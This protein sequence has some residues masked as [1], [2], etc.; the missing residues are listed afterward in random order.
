MESLIPAAEKLW[1]EWDLRTFVMISLLLQAILIF[2]GSL[3]KHTSNLLISLII[4]SAYLLA[5]WVAVFALG[6]LSNG[7]GNSGDSKTKTASDPWN[8]NDELLA[9][10]P[11][12][13]LLH[14]GGPDTITA[15]A[16]EDNEL[17]LRHLLGLIFQ[18]SVAIYVFQRSIRTTRL[19]A[20]AILMFF[21]GIVKY[22]ERTYALMSA[23]ADNLRSSMVSPPDPGPNYAKFMEEY[24]SKTNA[25]LD[26]RIKTEEEPDTLKFNVEEGTVFNDSGDSWILLKAKHFYLIFRCLIV[27]LILSFHDRNDSRSFFANLKAEKAFRVVEIE[28]SFIYQVL[29]TKAPVI[30]YKTVGPWLRVFT[31]TLM[32]ISLIL[33]IFTGKS[34]YRGMDVTVTYI[35]FGG[36]LFLETWAFTLLVSS[37]QAFLWLKGQERHKA[38][39]FVLSCISFPLSYRQNKP[40]WSRKM[41]QCNLM[42]ICLADEKHGVIAWIMSF[43]LVK[44]WC[45]RKDTPVSSPLLE[46]LFE[47]LKS[48]SSTAEDSRG[49]KRLCNSRGEL[50]LKMMGYH[51]MFGWSVNVDFDESILLWHIA[52]ELC[53]QHDNKKEN[54]NNRDIS[55]ALSDYMLYLLIFRPSMMTAGIG[56]IRYGDTVAETSNFFRRAVKKPDISEACKMLLKVEID[57]P[58]IQVKGDRSKSVLFDAC[59]LAKE[60]LK[61]KTKKWKIMDAVWTE[62]LCYAASHCKGYY[63][64]QRLSKGG[65]LL[66]FMWLLMAHLGIG[67]QF[68]I[69][70]GHARAKLIVGK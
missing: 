57:V 56:Q 3:R 24:A 63:H 8:R 54:V 30:Y 39:K 66:T 21:V 55:K 64:A 52:T 53:Y 45:Y 36:G 11:P 5:D 15:F 2:M 35:L 13:L 61:M 40:K 29:Y 4:W 47:E 33:F 20:P 25:G 68:Q 49:Y 10:W 41:A 1:N 44:E 6:I 38:A 14:L 60:L 65:E 17:W 28:L 46:F 26:V 16:L 31:F 12:F 58:P 9:F 22:G 48:K 51:E 32:S 34:G 62:M 42:S 19:H 67:E 18:V 70:A 50:A 69:E 27:D 37:D 59:R 23:S 43:D 7:Q